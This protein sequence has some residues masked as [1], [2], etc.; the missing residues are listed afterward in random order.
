DATVVMGLLFISVL[1]HEFGHCYGAHLVDGE[2]SEILMWPLG[3]LAMVEVPQTARA[4]FITTLMGPVVNLVLC[5]I[6]ALLL[7]LAVDPAFQPPWNPF[8]YIYR[9]PSSGG[10]DLTTWAGKTIE[11]VTNVWALTLYRLFWVN[12]ML[13]LLNVLIIGFPLDGGRLF[14]CLLWPRYGYRQAT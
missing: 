11:D 14:Q 2:A 4:N 7:W 1:L 9:E 12:W 5:V 8:T 6:A 3:G 10:M 13:F